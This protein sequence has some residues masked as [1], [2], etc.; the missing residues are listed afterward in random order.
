M[1]GVK[2]EP[3]GALQVESVDALSLDEALL[4]ARELPHLRELIRGTLPGVDR[5]TSRRLA[6]GVLTVAQGHPKLL[7]LADGQAADPV[8]LAALVEAGDQAWR[9]AGGLP[10]GFFATVES[11]APAT[12]ESVAPATGESGARA[13]GRASAPAADYLRVLAAWTTV[14]AGT[15]AVGERALFWF[16]CCL[17]EPDRDRA[18]LDGNWADLW[19]R[20]GLDGPKP[21]PDA[22]VKAIAGRGPVAVQGE[23]E[24]YAIHPGVA[25]AGRDQ[26]GKPFR[27]A[28]D[29]ESAA[30]WVAIFLY[31]SGETEGGAIDPGCRSGPGWPLSP[32]SC[33]RN[34]GRTRQPRSSAP[35]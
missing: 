20:L 23:P 34:S 18:V 21:E 15:L 5:D 8:R 31:A 33:A 4:L 29:A 3:I 13:A 27:E 12:V 32:T 9:A 30:F 16:L 1:G 2:R 26:A 10:D 11:V 28:V 6:L 35:S 24:S 14:V 7:E 19:A 22:A 17:E 25:A